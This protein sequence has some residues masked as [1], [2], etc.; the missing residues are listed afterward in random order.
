MAQNGQVALDA[1]TITAIPTALP[2][3]PSF[4]SIDRTP[5][6]LVTLVISNT[7]CLTLTLQISAD[8]T[9]WTTLATLTPGD[10]PTVFTD[11]TAAGEDKRFYRAFQ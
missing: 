6:G 10:S 2:G 5:D 7:P 3:T 8:V 9:N 1:N 11:T 4:L